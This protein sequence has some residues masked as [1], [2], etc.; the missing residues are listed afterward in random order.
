MVINAQELESRIKTKNA[1]LLDK[2]ETTIDAELEKN[3]CES[4]G[5]ILFSNRELGSLT[6]F[7]RETLFDRYRQAGWE[8]HYHYDQRDGDYAEFKIKRQE[9]GDSGQAYSTGGPRPY[10]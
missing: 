8:V 3:Y 10:E 1:K 4:K 6:N 9:S 2:L 7:L 5:S